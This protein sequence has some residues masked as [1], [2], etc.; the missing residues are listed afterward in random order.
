M[1]K[2]KIKL[3]VTLLTCLFSIPSYSEQYNCSAL[4]DDFR[5]EVSKRNVEFQIIRRND[6]YFVE[7][8]EENELRKFD[9]TKETN[10]FLILSKTGEFPTIS[11]KIISKLT[12]DFTSNFINLNCAGIN[13]CLAKGLK[14]KCEIG[15]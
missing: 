10:E 2:I 7:L 14:G 13:S 15:N 5:G 4:L 6:D 12:G 8:S 1:A 11:I 9:I 3:F